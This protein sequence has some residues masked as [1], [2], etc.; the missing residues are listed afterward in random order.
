MTKFLLLG[1]SLSSDNR[2]IDAITMGSIFCLKEYYPDAEFSIIGFT[3]PTNVVST[4]QVFLDGCQT[5]IDEA[6]TSFHNGVQMA[7]R[8]LLVHRLTRDVVLKYFWWADVIIDFSEGDGFGDTYGFKVLLRHSLGK[9][10][11]LHLGK[12]LAIFPQTMGP[13]RRRI[14]RLLARYLLRRADL[15]CVREQISEEIVQGVIGSSGNV[16]CLADMAFLM[17]EADISAVPSLLAECSRTDK[18]I[19]VNIS[20]FL[21]HRGLDKYSENNA[22]FDYQEMIVGM[23]RRLVQETDRPVVLIPH[24]FSENPGA[25]D[26][27]ACREAQELLRDLGGKVYLIEQNYSSPEIKAIIAQCEFFIGARM[28]ACIAALS[29]GTPVV[30]ISYSHKFAGI[31]QR[32]EIQDW[33]VDPNALSQEQAIDLVLLGYEHREE[34]RKRIITKLPLIESDAMR[35]GQL[36]RDITG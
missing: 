31:L 25:D 12:P 18:P 8:T 32:F 36:L 15:V 28:H 16:F 30:P 33:L 11:A 2:G 1:G 24:V 7:I 5:D 10:I 13:F 19:G 9:F 4:Q 29:T 23:I 3:F 6:K 34:I 14:S 26:L 20:G 17:K 21:W 35:A 27:F 22:A